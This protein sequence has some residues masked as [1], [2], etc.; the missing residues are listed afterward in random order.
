MLHGVG[1]LSSS[2]QGLDYVELDDG[3]WHLVVG[4]NEQFDLISI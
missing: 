1:V 3:E 2:I 4:A